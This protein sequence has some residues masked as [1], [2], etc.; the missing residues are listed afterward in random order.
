M[1]DNMR[2]KLLAKLANMWRA[3]ETNFIETRKDGEKWK[4]KDF[5]DK[6]NLTEKEAEELNNIMRSYGI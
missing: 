2:N 4:V 6:Q 1:Q 3:A 5:Q